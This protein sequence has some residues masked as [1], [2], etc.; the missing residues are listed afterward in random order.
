MSDKE[1][2]NGI[3]RFIIIVVIIAG[4]GY[5]AFLLFSNKNM[6]TE[7][8][9]ANSNAQKVYNAACAWVDSY[10]KP[11]VPLGSLQPKPTMI[12]HSNFTGSVTSDA[13][14]DN[15]Q[16]L[17]DLS[18]DLGETFSGDWV[19]VINANNMHIDYVI[20]SDQKIDKNNISRYSDYKQQKE[21]YKDNDSYIGYYS[22]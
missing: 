6:S 12:F 1:E 14:E 7:T 8:D 2:T 5:G 11:T 19:V 17:M 13:S 18:H 22:E 21:Y 15:N 4:L 3:V 16:T 9:K 20:W 10:S